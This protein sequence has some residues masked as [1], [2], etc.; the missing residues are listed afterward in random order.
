MKTFEQK[1]G[2]FW[3]TQSPNYILYALREFSGVLI[4]IW[5]IYTT[6]V[7]I[8]PGFFAPT[9]ITLIT[10][11]GL[12]GAIIHSLTWLWVMPKLLPQKLS[13]AVHLLIYFTLI[14]AWI[15]LSALLILWI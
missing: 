2:K 8:F 4:A 9:V 3:W 10:I 5:A 14:I 1:P 13:G 6:L 12:T 11:I 7:L 15:S